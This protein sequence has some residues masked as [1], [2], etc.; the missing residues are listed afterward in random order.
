MVVVGSG[1]PSVPIEGVPVDVRGFELGTEVEDFASLDVG[2]YPL[3][4]EPWAAGKSGLKA[5]QYL[6]VGVPY[7]ASPVGIVAEIGLPGVTHLLANDADDWQTALRLLLE[8]QQLRAEMGG[9]GRRYAELNYDVPK[10]AD[11]LAHALRDAAGR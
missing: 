3:P 10:A 8:D 9:A 7:I 11:L 6:A 5:I 1:R 2:L 4:D